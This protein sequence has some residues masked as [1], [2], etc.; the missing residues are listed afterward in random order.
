MEELRVPKKIGE[1]RL[2]KNR[3]RVRRK[4]SFMSICEQNWRKVRYTIKKE[5]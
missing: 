5:G 3:A 2:D 4:A 1:G